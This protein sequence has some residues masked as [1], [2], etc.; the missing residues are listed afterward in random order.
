MTA[1]HGRQAGETAE[2]AR[3]VRTRADVARTAFDVLVEEGSE[4]LTHAR[5]AERAGV[6]QNH[7]LQALAREVRPG[8]HSL[9]GLARFQ[10]LPAHGRYPR[11][12]DRRAHDVSAGGSRPAA[13]PRALGDGP[14]GATL[15]TMRHVRN[16]INSEGQRPIRGILEKAFEGPELEAAISM[17]SGVVAC[18]SLMFGTVP[19][20]DVIEAAV[21]IVLH[22]ARPSR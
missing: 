22:R 7:P 4:A 21:D 16:E 20:Y 18:P 9:G 8:N 10:A 6:L 13:R 5:V 2:D 1:G 12:S 11:R 14:V 15:D 17:L 3:I 19:D